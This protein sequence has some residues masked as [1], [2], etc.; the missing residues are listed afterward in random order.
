MSWSSSQLGPTTSA[1]ADR[2]RFGKFPVGGDHDDVT[3]GLGNGGDGVVSR[4][5][6]MH[7]R[8]SVHIGLIG[9]GPDCNPSRLPSGMG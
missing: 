2:T 5:G 8:H 7:D 4:A 6:S 1:F 9:S 3:I